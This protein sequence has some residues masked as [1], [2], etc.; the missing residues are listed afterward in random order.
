[1]NIIFL[2]IDGVLNNRN[3]LIKT[4]DDNPEMRKCTR[5]IF[6]DENINNLKELLKISGAKIVISSCW[7]IGSLYKSLIKNFVKWRIIDY[8][9]DVTPYLGG[10]QR[11]DEIRMWLSDHPEVDKFVIIDDDSDMCEF[12][13]THLVKTDYD[14]GLT[15]EVVEKALKI[16]R[17]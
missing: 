12:T 16:L 5:E 17:E 1:M 2:D 10:Q 4:I 3:H 14:F 7:R 6:D 11:G 8:L 15:K 13:N 9:Y